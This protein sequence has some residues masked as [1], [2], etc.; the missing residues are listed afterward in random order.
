M[1]GTSHYDP[2]DIVGS[3]KIVLIRKLRFRVSGGFA[4]IVRGTEVEGHALSASERA[5]LGRLLD[6]SPSARAPGARDQVVYEWDV[7]TDAGQRRVECDELNVPDDLA[8]LVTKL[9]GQ[10][11]PVTP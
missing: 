7:D 4:G 8:D 11:R 2:D 10:S 6:A 1:A 3:E 9:T 5:A